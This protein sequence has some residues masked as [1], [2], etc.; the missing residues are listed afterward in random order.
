MS[1]I[2]KILLLFLLK[3]NKVILSDVG[4]VHI[5]LTNIIIFKRKVN[6]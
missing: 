5:K 2:S 1:E 6:K 3:T 4:N